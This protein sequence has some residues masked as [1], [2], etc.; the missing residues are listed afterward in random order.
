MTDTNIDA[1]FPGQT[2]T[3]RIP[4]HARDGANLYRQVNV[5]GDAPL[6]LGSSPINNKYYLPLERGNTGQALT[7]TG[8]GACDWRWPTRINGISYPVEIT[9]DEIGRPLMALTRTGINTGPFALPLGTGT[10]GQYLQTDGVGGSV[11]ATVVKNDEADAFTLPDEVGTNGQFLQTDGVGGSV[12]AN[13][14]PTDDAYT[15]TTVSVALYPVLASDSVI[16]VNTSSNAVTIVLPEI[17][18]LRKLSIVDAG[19]T[20][21]INHITVSVPDG[22]DNRI[23]GD[24]SYV[25]MGNY[26]SITLINDNINGWYLL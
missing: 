21:S 8:H 6:Y 5:V 14:A 17:N 12:W 23:I 2:F 24:I 10:S 11:W 18:G 15:W 3:V 20:A 26:S 9:P 16:G 22:S 1:K 19:G 25:I 4:F 13:V 7:Y